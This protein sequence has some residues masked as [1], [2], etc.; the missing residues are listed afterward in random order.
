MTGAAK[1]TVDIRHDGQ[2]EG[3][4]LRSPAAHA[5]I[6]GLDL[7]PALAIPGVAAAISLLG[8]DNIVRYVGAPIAAVA[9]KDRKTA[10]AAI[11][12]IRFASERLPSVI[13]LDAARRAMRRSCS[14]SPLARTPA[15]SPKAAARRRRGSGTSAARPRPSRTRR[16]S[17][18][19]LGHCG[20]RNARSVAGRG[21]IPHRDA[22]P[23][24]PR[25]ACRCRPLRWRSPHRAC[26]D[27]SGV[28]FDG[29]DRQTLQA[30]HTT[31][32]A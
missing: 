31:R 7:A 26:L 19:S 2:L 10:L 12:A 27:A 9:A 20:A 8:D 18:Q 15:T 11:A 17:A 22:V 14:K 16:R 28:P 32:C 24:M 29:A 21:D 23:C 5:R 4:I 13:G 1:Y 3:V 25:A 6:A 30:R